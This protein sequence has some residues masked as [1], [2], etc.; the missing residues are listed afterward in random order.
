MNIK[1]KKIYL[2]I[3]ILVFIIMQPSMIFDEFFS[4]IGLS[5]KFAYYLFFANILYIAISYSKVVKVHRVQRNILFMLITGIIYL[6]TIEIFQDYT[7]GISTGI[8]NFSTFTLLTIIISN[9]KFD[10]PGLIKAYIVLAFILSILSL[11][12]YGA[13]ILGLYSMNYYTYSTYSPG[14]SVRTGLGGFADIE[15]WGYLYRNQSFF[16]EPARFA[17]FLIIPLFLSL[18]KTL[19]R[20]KN[21]ISWL[22]ITIMILISFILTFSVA[23]YFGAMVGAIIILY[24]TNKITASKYAVLI[25]LFTTVIII[26]MLFAVVEFYNYT[27]SND[28]FKYS[29]NLLGKRTNLM[30]ADRLFRFE[31]ALDIVKDNFFGNPS[32]RLEYSTNTTALGNALIIGG[33]PL[34]VLSIIFALYIFFT[35]FVKYKNY[36]NHYIVYVSG[37]SYFLAF[38]WYGSFYENLYLFNFILLS[39][40]LVDELEGRATFVSRIKK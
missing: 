31:T 19:N 33:V 15:S 32:I 20:N 37:I 14:Y 34:G 18:N 16:I 26:I 4:L 23:N 3:S 6:I 38:N 25:R 21:T 36:R 35:I 1:I 27:N 8:K 17:Q 13:H 5:P 7:V 24:S 22:F 9:R 12:Q 30:M 40:I 10:L 2:N 11:L 28:Y 29:G 39:F